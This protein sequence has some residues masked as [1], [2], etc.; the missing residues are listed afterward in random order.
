MGFY[1]WER[2]SSV[3]RPKRESTSAAG[4]ADG[5]SRGRRGAVGS[6]RVASPWQQQQRQQQWVEIEALGMLLLLLL[7]EGT[8]Q[9]KPGQ[10]RLKPN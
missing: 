3:G 2:E 7:L 8:S 1:F 4:Q 10:T 9:A 5:R 6:G